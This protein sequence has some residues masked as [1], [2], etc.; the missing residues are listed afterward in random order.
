MTGKMREILKRRSL[1]LV[2]KTI[3]ILTA[4]GSTSNNEPPIRAGAESIGRQVCE[5]PV[6]C[7]GIDR[8]A[9]VGETVAFYGRGASS[10]EEIVEYV[11]DFEP[12]GVADFTSAE[13]GLTK[14]RFTTAGDYSCLLAIRDSR[15]RI[16]QDTRR[17]VVITDEADSASAAEFLRP[18][19]RPMVCKPADCLT[20]RFAIIINGSNEARHW[21]D[22][23]L[24][25]DMLV[26]RYGL[27]TTDVYVINCLG[28]DP[29]GNNP[30]GMVDCPANHKAM[31]KTFEG[32]AARAD[33]DDVLYIW[34]TGHGRGYE[35][36]TSRGQNYFGYLSGRASVD[37]GDEVDFLESDF[38]LRVIHT[39]GDYP[40]T[41]GMNAW[42]A[43]LSYS[44]YSPRLYRNMYVSRFETL[45]VESEGS[46][47]CDE[48]VFIERLVDYA[49][50]D[51]DRDGYIDP[52]KGET[53]D[54]DGDGREAYDPG[55]G[56]FDEDEWGEV[57]IL[58]DDY[59]Q[60]NNRLTVDA[61]PIRLFD[62]GH[63]GRICVDLGSD[64]GEPRVDGCDED[65]DGLLDW[66]DANQDGDTY[67]VISVDEAVC[68]AMSDM[69][70]DELACY[71]NEAS[72]GKVVVVAQSCYSGGLVDDLSSSKRIV[73]T[74][75]KE[76]NVS[77]GGDFVRA[78]VSALAGY[79]QWG[80]PVDVDIN[81]NGYVSMVEAFNYSASRDLTGETPQYDDNGDGVSNACPIPSGGDGI[82]GFHTYLCDTCSTTVCPGDICAQKVILAEN[83]PNPFSVQTT[84][85]YWLGWP[86][87]VSLSIFDVEGRGV[88][89]LELG[90][91]D[92]GPHEAIWNGIDSEGRRVPSGIYFYRLDVEGYGS[93][94]R[95]MI[96]LR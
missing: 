68:L 55:S 80:I 61:Y 48:D 60:I 43:Y 58:Q 69:Y 19:K 51:L 77:W 6:A 26:K 35:G 93:E 75:T 9:I 44:G 7:A 76:E 2:I 37:P 49:L 71:L 39:G 18:P 91:N 28:R 85:Y 32:I 4:A 5:R 50:G 89:E 1:H 84:I 92:G 66:I 29:W 54:L 17:V 10:D 88:V 3:V 81:G 22:V 86:S 67:D 96:F 42:A 31:R 14:H 78:L 20:H 83:R 73:S 33:E 74:A 56:E 59:N 94:S 21:R 64:D 57:D 95:S 40:S 24:I 62:Q 30:E 36:T 41:H 25:Y 38:K 8:I 72:I 79:D 15:G 82:L 90:W 45:Y 52:A 12:D 11:W 63:R 46:R 87:S 16:A 23:E 27:Y 65:N 13:T 70:D 47:L 53:S 34:I